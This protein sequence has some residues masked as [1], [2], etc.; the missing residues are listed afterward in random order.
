ILG[1]GK[2]L[3]SRDPANRVLHQAGRQELRICGL[4]AFDPQQG[5]LVLPRLEWRRC[6]GRDMMLL[7]LHSDRSLRDDA[8]TARDFLA[9]MTTAQAIPG[10]LPPRPS[11]RHSSD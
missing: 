5:R 8:V 4:N 11:E 6:G 1:A 2:S 9:S 10:A 3:P 7:V